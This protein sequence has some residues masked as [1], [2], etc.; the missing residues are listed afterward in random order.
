MTW[1]ETVRLT[2]HFAGL[3]AVEDFNMEVKKGEIL[4]LIGPNG[5]GKTTVLKLLTGQLE[6]I[7]GHANVLGISPFKDPLAVKKAIGIVPEIESPP[8]FL[9]GVE[10]LQYIG[11]IREIEDIDEKVK[12]WIDFL[13]MTDV[14]N[15][16]CK[17]MSKGT[18]QKLMIAAAFIHQP[19][20]VF[21]DEPLTGLD[22]YYQKQVRDYIL[23][24]ITKGGTIFMCTHILEIAEKM[25]TRIAI[26]NRGKIVAIGTV[27]ELRQR[28]EALD[29]AFLRYTKER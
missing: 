12:Y 24:Y 1:F 8:S 5:A 18:R 19:S 29:A 11:L 7:S 9:T 27:E 17:D 16:P 15:K 6:P 14:Q 26:I 13:D 25:C 3:S 28:G 10:Y 21:L 23:N 22:P 4:G 20:L 2:K